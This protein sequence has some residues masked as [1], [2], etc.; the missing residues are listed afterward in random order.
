MRLNSGFIKVITIITIF[1]ITSYCQ[2]K[3][4]L[5]TAY[6]AIADGQTNNALSIQK[7]INEASENGGGK[8]IVPYGNFATGVIF[9]KSNVELHIDSGGRLLGSVKRADYDNPIALALIVAKDQKNISI[10]GGGIIDG[11]ATE[12]MKNIFQMLQDGTLSDPQWEFKR[13]TESCRPYLIGL[14]NC[15]HVNV[16]D[17]T[18]MNSSCW[19]QVY[20]RCSDLVIN[21]IKVES[22]SYWNNDG[23]DISDCKDVK[24]TNCNVNSAD[25]GIC[26]K[27]EFSGSCCEDVYIADCIIRSSASAFKMGTASKGGFKNITVRNLTIYDTYRSAIAIECVDGGTVENINIEKITAKNTGN[28]IFIRLGHRNLDGAVGELKGIRIADIK[29]EIP[30]R[31]PDLGYPFEGPPDH[32]R[33]LYLRSLKE[34]PN[35]GYPFVGQPAYPYN[36]IPSSIVGIPGYPVKDVTLENIE[37]IFGGAGNK[38]VAH[39]NLDSLNKIPEKEDDYPEFSMFGE[40]PAW[41]FYIRHADGINMQNVKILYRNFD[42]RPALVFDDVKDINLKDIQIPTG[43]ELPV[44]LFNNTVN[45]KLE[46][47]IL[48]V[49]S[50]KGIMEK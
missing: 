8:V 2:K 37:I 27:S 39:V 26:L 4:Y 33:G 48:P 14:K 17:V 11:Q 31:K 49:E 20:D 12:L 36:L 22:T 41:G 42:F 38:E 25:D 7:A 35:L 10:T 21:N 15:S 16:T 44:I 28:A 47:I 46:N 45:K 24:V 6:G 13:P 5:V 3:E 9:L 19:V 40:L 30:L 34:R 23:I 50:G 1:F 29:A 43:E 32:L 18:V